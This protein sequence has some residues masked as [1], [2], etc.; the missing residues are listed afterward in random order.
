MKYNKGKCTARLK[1]KKTWSACLKQLEGTSMSFVAL[2]D[3]RGCRE[4]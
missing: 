1:E 3:I 4:V 2:E